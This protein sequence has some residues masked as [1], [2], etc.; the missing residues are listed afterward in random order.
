MKVSLI[1][2]VKDAG[3][4]IHAFIDSVRR[5]TRQPDEVIVVDGGSTDG[6]AEALRRADGITLIEE[7][8][9]GIGMGRNIA[10][11]AATHEVVAVT[12]ADCV[13]DPGWL[14][15]LLVP[16]ERGADVS[17]GV[18]RPVAPTFWQVCASANVPDPEELR[19]GWLPSSRSLAFRREVFEDAGGYPE[20]LEAGEDMYLNHRWVER[21]VRM[22]LAP[23]AVAYWRIRPTIR[24]TWRQY[25][26]YAEGDAVG[27]MY[28]HRHALRFATYLGLAAILASRRG[29]VLA[30]GAV[31]GALY[32]AKPMRRAWRRLPSGVEQVMALGGVPAATAFLDA[33]KMWG[34]LR[35]RRRMARP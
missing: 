13:L 11:R 10:V 29:P 34:Y 24:Q 28:P 26:R 32:V 31:A 3:S 30:A 22:E 25:E 19:P 17:A 2:T 6:T 18:Y 15:H 12:D 9:A 33:A 7:P 5:Q 20:W 23:D 1:A 35:G 27:R 4:A 14:Q 8:G 21:G 16:M